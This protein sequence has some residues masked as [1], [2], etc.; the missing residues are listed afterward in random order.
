MDCKNFDLNISSYVDD[1]LTQEEKQIFEKHMNECD[2]C[3]IKYDNFVFMIDAVNETDEIALPK[4]FTAELSKRLREDT[5][6]K[7]KNLPKN[8]KLI[9]A[10]AASMLVVVASATMLM[11]SSPLNTKSTSDQAAGE[12]GRMHITMTEEAD[13]AMDFGAAE[14]PRAARETENQAFLQDQEKVEIEAFTDDALGMETTITATERKIIQRGRMAL[15]VE[16]FDE[17]HDEVLKIVENANGYIQHREVYYYHQDRMN[18]EES[19]KNASMELRI[20]SQNFVSIFDR[21]KELGTVVEE[22]T[23]GEDI[24]DSYLDIDNQVTNL[25]VQEERLRDILQRAE[26]VE[27]LLQIENELNRIRTQINYLTGTLKNYDG[28]VSMATINLHIR[29]VK[30]SNIAI[31]SIDEGLWS[32]A[33]SNFVHSINSIIKLFERGFIGLFGALP[34]LMLLAIIGSPIGYFAYKKWHKKI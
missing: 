27:D 7:K 13:M 11:N 21:V 32:R 12:S 23:S 22:N 30:E 4:N 5:P 28:L 15:E 9:T 31:Q 14:A 18:P 24:T 33:K 25:K 10:I 1:Y 16:N 3:K 17:V 2:L 29:Q 8:W 20:P 26:K 6:Q 34:S 19:L